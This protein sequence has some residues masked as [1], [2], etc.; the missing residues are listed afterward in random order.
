M[1]GVQL[2]TELQTKLLAVGLS[3]FK[4]SSINNVKK[5]KDSLKSMKKNMIK[6]GLVPTETVTEEMLDNKEIIIIV[7]NFSL[8]GPNFH[9]LNESGEP[10]I[11]KEIPEVFP[12]TPF[13]E[14]KAIHDL[15]HRRQ[16]A[17]K[18]ALKDSPRINE[19]K[20]LH[21]Q[22]INTF[23]ESKWN[24]ML[25]SFVDVIVNIFLVF[26]SLSVTRWMIHY[27][28]ATLRIL[29]NFS[30]AIKVCFRFFTLRFFIFSF[31][32]NLFV[33]VFCMYLK[34]I[35]EISKVTT[36]SYFGSISNRK[37]QLL[38]NV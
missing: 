37:I 2:D 17:Y 28:L 31:V 11:H 33:F 3:E 29:L 35:E 25:E 7:R 13:M 30:R 20:N 1:Q 12:Q 24:S 36:A 5:T 6:Y 9:A 19:I 8:D 21:K 22:G 26:L 32:I 27:Y 23:K 18:Q 10:K 15:D 16:L 34:C 14:D 38:K 4:Y